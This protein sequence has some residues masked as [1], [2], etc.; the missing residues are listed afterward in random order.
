MHAGRSQKTEA[1]LSWFA[2]SSHHPAHHTTS[3][4]RNNGLVTVVRLGQTAV[5]GHWRQVHATAAHHYRRQLG[6]EQGGREGQRGG[7]APGVHHLWGPF[8]VYANLVIRVVY[9]FDVACFERQPEDS[10]GSLAGGGP[11]LPRQLDDIARA[12]AAGDVGEDGTDDGRL[13]GSM[14]VL[15]LD[16]SGEDEGGDGGPQLEL[17]FSFSSAC[18]ALDP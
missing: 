14:Q 16:G 8:Y 13:D 9:V 15:P 6:V 3:I 12:A 7:L 5:V 4:Q 11:M 18:L 10:E 1:G 2:P 17:S